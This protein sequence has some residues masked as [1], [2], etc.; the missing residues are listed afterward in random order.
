MVEVINSDV[1]K[2]KFLRP[3]PR[4]IVWSQTDLVLRP[5]VS[6]HIT[7]NQV[8]ASV[9]RGFRHVA[10]SPTAFRHFCRYNPRNY[11]HIF[12]I[13][14][15]YVAP[16]Q[17]H[18]ALSTRWQRADHASST[19]RQKNRNSVS[20]P[21]G[22]FLFLVVRFNFELFNVIFVCC[23]ELSLWSKKLNS[24]VISEAI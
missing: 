1:N 17:G 10:A 23:L 12:V 11:A 6:D 15:W 9:R 20:R 4:P 19:R 24:L 16:L 14:G 18:H 13:A 5:T 3:R 7:G 8:I 2:T 22:H 21:V